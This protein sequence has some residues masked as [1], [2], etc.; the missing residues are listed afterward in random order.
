MRFHVGDINHS[1]RLVKALVPE[2][3]AVVSFILNHHIV[4]HRRSSNIRS[5]MVSKAIDTL[6]NQEPSLPF[7]V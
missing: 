3:A 6:V 5:Y 2:I 7:M 4:F 1:S